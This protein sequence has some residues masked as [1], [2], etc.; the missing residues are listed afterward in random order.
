MNYN[1]L[2]LLLKKQASKLFKDVMKSEKSEK[3][4]VFL[5]GLCSEENWRTPIKKDYEDKIFF[6]DPYDEKWKPDDNIYDEVAGM[7]T[8]DFVIFYKG[9][10]GT[11]R[12]KKLLKF[13]DEDY[14]EFSDLN[15]IRNYLDRI[16]KPVK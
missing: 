5:G 3:I 15:K 2:S 1:I 8:A 10:I 16:L 6:I 14:E 13:L 4:V 12:E 9:G 11:E 7:L